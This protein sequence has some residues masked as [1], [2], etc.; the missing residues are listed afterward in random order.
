MADP[1]WAG[2]IPPPRVPPQPWELDQSCVEL[3]ARHP[4]AD[5]GTA[6]GLPHAV[7]PLP[8]GGSVEAFGHT[9]GEVIARLRKRA[10][11]LFRRRPAPPDSG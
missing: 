2:L 3:K 9:W 6:A 8:P 7:V 10:P 11:E 4:E 1:F 5:L